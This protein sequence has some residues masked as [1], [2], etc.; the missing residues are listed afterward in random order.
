[1]T[2]LIGGAGLYLDGTVGG[3]GHAAELLDRCQES[4]LLGL[5]RDP[6]A[7]RA[8]GTRLRPFGDRV[9]LRHLSFADAGS[10]LPRPAGEGL[11]GALLDLG[12]SS[13]QLDCDQRGF[14]FRRG[15][16]LDMRMDPDQ[17]SP[18]A[19][20][21]LE[22]ASEEVLARVFRAGGVPRARALARRIRTRRERRRCQNSDDL[23]GILESVLGRRSTHREKARLFQALRVFVNG[24]LEA[25]SRALPAIRDRLTPGGVFAVIS[26]H[27]GEDRIVKRAFSVM[28]GSGGR[29]AGKAS[30]SLPGDAPLGLDAHRQACPGQRP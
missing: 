30:P 13:H 15:A 20:D 5:D 28:V 16:P 23:I 9:R 3:G 22:N 21:L 26:Y 4:R 1:M 24:E 2:V 7:L 29:S 10:C 6:E 12:V 18:S 25:L 27:S 19:A 14:T 8:A 11:A 17:D